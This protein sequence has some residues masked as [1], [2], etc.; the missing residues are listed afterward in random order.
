MN[1]NNNTLAFA[2]VGKANKVERGLEIL[3]KRENW[4]TLV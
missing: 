4:P 3:L 2:F 1:L